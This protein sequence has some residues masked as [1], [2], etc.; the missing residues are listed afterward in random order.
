MCNNVRMSLPENSPKLTA[1]LNIRLSKR[2]RSEVEQHARRNFLK[3]SQFG[4]VAI[5]QLIR[6]VR[7]GKGIPQ[8]GE[9]R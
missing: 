9:G 2:E 6:R 4:R 3:A 7:R 5:Q 1:S 8:N